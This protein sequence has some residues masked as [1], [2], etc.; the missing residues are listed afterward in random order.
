MKLV[1]VIIAVFAVIGLG[2]GV[3]ADLVRSGKIHACK[4]AEL[5][6]K[7]Q[8]DPSNTS[9]QS[10]ARER[11]ALLKTVIESADRGGRADL[12]KAIAAAVAEGCN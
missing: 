6:R 12:E 7:M 3:D 8:A 1:L 4:L 10:E 2:C 9:L 11:A 5:K